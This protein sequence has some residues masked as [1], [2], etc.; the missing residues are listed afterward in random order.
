MPPG[1][2]GEDFGRLSLTTKLFEEKTAR[3]KMYQYGGDPAHGGPA[4]RSDCFDYFVSKCPAAGPWLSWA[5]TCGSKEITAA[6]IEEMRR[7]N[8]LMTDELNPS[9]LA[10]HVWGFLHHCLTG[11]GRQVFK[12]ADRQDGFN[13]WRRLCL[14]INSRTDCVRHHLR[15]K[16][17]LFPQAANNGQVWRALADWEAVYA[18]YIDAGG[19]HMDFEDRRDQFLRIMPRALRQDIFRRMNTFET[20]A[21]MKEW[22]RTQLELEK[23][24][25]DID[26]RSGKPLNVMDAYGDGNGDEEPGENEMDALLALNE[27]STMEEVMAVQQRFRRFAQAGKSR[28][29]P[30]KGGGKGKSSGKG[31]GR[32]GAGQGQGRLPGDPKAAK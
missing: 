17:Q 25:G 12:S 8:A 29:A 23:D 32:G 30:G 18:D 2:R 16:C 4:W 9:V 11:V 13:I 27:D 24:W 21:E 6:A 26:R 31:T 14:E 15:N 19:K 3:E 22:V 5:E 10:H 20:I 28:Q 7:S 1:L